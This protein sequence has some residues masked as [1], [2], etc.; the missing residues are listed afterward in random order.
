MKPVTR[1]LFYKYAYLSNVNYAPNKETAVFTVSYCD[2][3]TNGYT[4]HLYTYKN[5]SVKQLTSASKEST[6]FFEDDTT[7]VFRA[8][9]GKQTD[10]HSS[11]WY[12]ISLNGGE[13]QEAFTLP[14]QIGSMKVL[15]DKWYLAVA[16]I[17]VTHPD[18]YALTK[19]QQEAIVKE[20]KEN[21]DYE[22][23]DEYPFFFN[24]A[25]FINHN[26]EHLF[27]IDRKTLEITPVCPPAMTVETYDVNN[28]C[29]KLLISAQKYQSFMGKWSQVYEYDLN[30]NTLTEVYDGTTMQIY[31]V[32][33]DGDKKIALGTFAEEW[34]AIENGKFY[35]LENNEMTLLADWDR[36]MHNSVGSDCRYG[37]TKGFLH[38]GKN[39]YF[40]SA[41]NG[42][43]VLYQWNGNGCDTVID[44]EGT[45]DD[46]TIG[47]D[48][49]L[50][51][52]LYDSRLQEL[53]EVRNGQFTQVS[54]F[55]D[56]VL[57]GYYVAKPIRHVMKKDPFDIDGWVLLPKDYDP[58]KKYPAVLDIHG[59]PKCAYGE[60]FYHE[61]QV[62]A[63]MGYF[64]FFCNPRG[65]DGKGNAFADLRHNFGKIDYEDLMDYTDYILS[66]YPA[67][68]SRRMAV[69]GGSYGGYMTN[70]V[71]SQTDRFA[72]A[73]TQRSISNWISEVTSSDYGID[74]A[75]EQEFD[76]MYHCE[77][78]L[79]EMSPLKYVNNVVTP[80]L[81]IHSFEDYRCPIDQAY[82]YYTSIRC[83]G[84]DSK[85]V[86][87][88]GEN[89]ELSR[90]GK[91]L[92]RLKR[93]NEITDWIVKYTGE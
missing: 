67:I 57:E 29:T 22:I 18:Y 50:V 45:V 30:T 82:A 27:L 19:E 70:W 38:E 34:G 86:L 44:K 41:D 16:T 12:R 55:N 93:L 52:G 31:R 4:Q 9:R 47:K 61:M 53:Y 69:T 74:F 49:Y 2:P 85:M 21:E 23:V 62:W 80:I 43:S 71:V 46:F 24:G 58:V 39:T 87:F 33:W 8:N 68:D 36:S 88:K 14:L 51:I 72:C 48:G 26:R 1:D 6:Y 25:G 83:R 54:H 56:E 76:D 91:P 5:G 42:A 11:K 89:H 66:L 40:V 60:V 92:H 90:A 17:D 77:K 78:E 65:G 79:W 73:A 3:D 81:F 32:F 35:L 84:V 15:N 28:D 64:V 13:A 10:P 59:G 75:I 63:S 20:E 37:K 7:V